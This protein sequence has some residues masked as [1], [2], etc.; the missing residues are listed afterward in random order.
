MVMRGEAA[1]YMEF[2]SDETP[3]LKQSN[4]K[5]TLIEDVPML[6]ASCT[7][8]QGDHIDHSIIYERSSI[9]GTGPMY[10]AV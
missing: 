7:V 9:V 6:K 8:V 10:S 3:G 5:A 4:Y 1:L 2:R